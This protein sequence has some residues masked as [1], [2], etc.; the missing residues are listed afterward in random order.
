M[1]NVEAWFCFLGPRALYRYCWQ[2]TEVRTRE[3]GYIIY[4]MMPELFITRH[5]K[6]AV[7][8]KRLRDAENE[9]TA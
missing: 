5:S 3:I 2:A 1:Y 6:C 9:A 7:G 4:R 8:I